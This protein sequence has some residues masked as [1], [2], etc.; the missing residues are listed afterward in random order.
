[1]REQP[2]I[3][4]V[5][6]YASDARRALH[7]LHEHDFSSD[8]ITAAFRVAGS[9]R[10]EP[11]GNS[12]WF[13]QLRQIYR[14]D[15][16]PADSD[17]AVVFG[18]MLEQIQLTREDA[19]ALDADLARGGGIIAV[20]GRRIHDAESLFRSAGAGIILGYERERPEWGHRNHA[21]HVVHSA[22]YTTPPPPDPG[23][24]QLF[25][26][27]LRVHKEKVGGGD[28]RVRKESVTEM[29]TVHVPVTREHLVVDHPGDGEVD[30]EKALRIPLSEEQVHIDKETVLRDEFKVG[31]REV[32]Q[33]EI[34]ADTVKRERL[35]VDDADRQGGEEIS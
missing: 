20:R 6:H 32:T 3:V 31:K 24:I 17:S 22:P 7:V 33:N 1:M 28:T 10:R 35:I 14:G 25:G 15:E 21:N 5:F 34:V 4:G 13:D 18:T 26:E 2:V 27:V 30:G 8:Q 19:A 23:H 29:E 16:R 12:Q 9:S 11:G